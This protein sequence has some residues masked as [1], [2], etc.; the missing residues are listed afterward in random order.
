MTA[1]NDTARWRPMARSDLRAAI[2]LADRVHPGLPEEE[3][4]FTDRLH[5]CPAGCLVLADPAG[6]MQ[7]LK[8]QGTTLLLVEQNARAALKLADRGYVIETGS[9]I[10][11]GT[12]AELR[13]SPEVQRAYLGKGYQEVW[14]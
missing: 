11:D 6:I 3:A 14:E 13:E 4:V 7:E 10:L 9:I 1:R 2:A 8:D 5:L 12:A